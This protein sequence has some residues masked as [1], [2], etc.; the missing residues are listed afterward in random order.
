MNFCTDYNNF[1]DNEIVNKPGLDPFNNN[2]KLDPLGY[3]LY[4][5]S[6]FYF[7]QP[8]FWERERERE[9]EATQLLCDLRTLYRTYTH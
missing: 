5:H 9:R 3:D 7:S 2:K 4:K 1:N 8:E 6:G